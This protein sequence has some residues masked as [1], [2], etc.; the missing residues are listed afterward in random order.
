M[1]LL[2]AALFA[3]GCASAPIDAE[4]AYGRGVQ[5]W[6][7]RGDMQLV[8]EHDDIY[9]YTGGGEA[10]YRLT[11]TDNISEFNPRFSPSGRNISYMFYEGGYPHYVVMDLDGSNKREISPREYRQLQ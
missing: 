11:D 1:V 6:E 8:T 5:V 2:A 7:E 4:Y 3:G 10:V 9:L